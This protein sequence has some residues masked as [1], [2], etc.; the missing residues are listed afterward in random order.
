MNP[1]KEFIFTLMDHY[2]P[3]DYLKVSKP[4]SDGRGGVAIIN[5]RIAYKVVHLPIQAEN[6]LKLA[7]EKLPD[8]LKMKIERISP[9]AITLP[10]RPPVAEPDEDDEDGFVEE[11]KPA[12]K[13]GPKPKSNDLA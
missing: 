8:H 10:K 9:N 12:V 11:K 6:E 1:N 7:N 2:F 5:D 13:R 4:Q 3:G